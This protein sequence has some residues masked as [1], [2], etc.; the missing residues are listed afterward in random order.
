MPSLSI[1]KRLGS[2]SVVN[3]E[4]LDGH[5]NINA[6]WVRDDL[7]GIHVAIILIPWSIDFI[8]VGTLVFALLPWIRT[9]LGDTSV[10]AAT[11]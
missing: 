5:P 6:E 10:R 1:F 11:L 7:V 2:R 8:F 9:V 4:A 3:V